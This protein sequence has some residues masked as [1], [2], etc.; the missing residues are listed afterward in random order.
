MLKLKIYS[1]IFVIYEILAVLLMHCPRTCDALFSGTFCNDS[2]FKYFIVCFAIPAL[3]FLIVMWIM[4]I[5]HAVR[6]SHSV[7]YR[8]KEAV[9]DVAHNIRRDVGNSISKSDIE[10]YITAA[11]VAGAQRYVSKHPEI[12]QKLSGFMD[13]MGQGT[14]EMDLDIEEDDVMSRGQ[15]SRT[16]NRSNANQKKKRK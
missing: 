12:K 7:F 6:R 9:E 3:V 1:T 14:Y 2:A 11:L 15:T 16:A 4:H 5:I 10:K 8:A 13:K